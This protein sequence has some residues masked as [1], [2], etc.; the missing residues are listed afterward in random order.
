MASY[1]ELGEDLAAAIADP[2]DVPRD[3]RAL[4]RYAGGRRA[5]V[6]QLTGLDGP[7]KRSAYPDDAQYAAA[8]TRWRT[9][10][11]R[12]RRY[13][14]GL[15][16]HAERLQPAQRRRVRAGARR[17]KRTRLAST[18]MRARIRAV[19]V[20]PSPGGRDDRRERDLPSGGPGVLLPVSASR[21]VFSE[22]RAGDDAAAGEAFLPAFFESYGFPE[23][24]QIA[25][26]R[27]VRVWP[28]G[29]PEPRG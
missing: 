7:P 11:Q 20:V 29:T 5:L 16:Q 6:E 4:V 14:E 28:D 9:A 8:R 23:S 18:P 27:W 15:R 1:R 26:V 21:E 2:G 25:E 24:G 17:E 13:D 3:G 12:V 19:V 22:A 10:T